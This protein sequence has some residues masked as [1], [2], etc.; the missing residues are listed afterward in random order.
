MSYI[1]AEG[2]K[3]VVYCPESQFSE[4]TQNPRKEA[5]LVLI[6]E[7]DDE[8]SVA[9]AVVEKKAVAEMENEVI[10]SSL[11]E[12]SE[13]KDVKTS[14]TEENEAIE[15]DPKAKSLDIRYN[16]TAYS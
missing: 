10:E 15:K 1:N 13:A 3:V 14:N 6:K 11:I 16:E 2:E 5:E 8:C 7:T 9:R 4:A 12:S